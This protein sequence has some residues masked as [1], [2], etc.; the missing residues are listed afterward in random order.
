MP[1]TVG[2]GLT[3]GMRI[4]F[5]VKPSP[6]FCLFLQGLPNSPHNDPQRFSSAAEQK[7]EHRKRKE[8][9]LQHSWSFQVHLGP[10]HDNSLSACPTPLPHSA[11]LSQKRIFPAQEQ[12][13][14][15]YSHGKAL[16]SLQTGIC[17]VRSTAYQQCGFTR[18]PH[19]DFLSTLEMQ[20]FFIRDYGFS[21]YEYRRPL[22]LDCLLIFYLLHFIFY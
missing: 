17:S 6:G 19:P 9:A 4:L 1:S 8:A 10:R 15:H 18:L 12:N 2:N 3:S 13:W 11:W 16:T 21:L 20:G 22:A 5:H 7:E 14:R